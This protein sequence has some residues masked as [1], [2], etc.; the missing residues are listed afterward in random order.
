MARDVRTTGR[1]DAAEPGDD[2]VAV[3]NPRGR[4]VRLRDAGLIAAMAESVRGGLRH[5]VAALPPDPRGL[6]PG[7]VIGDTSRTPAD[8]TEA[9]RPPA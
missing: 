4:P 6:L 1:L 5:A 3:L 7:L 2:V 8:L 9:M